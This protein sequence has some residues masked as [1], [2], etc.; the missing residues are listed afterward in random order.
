[1]REIRRPGLLAGI[2]LLALSLIVFAVY[3]HWPG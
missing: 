3:R 2:C 1:M